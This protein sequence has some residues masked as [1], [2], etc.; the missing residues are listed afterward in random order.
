LKSVALSIVRGT[1]SSSFL[2]AIVTALDGQRLG[3]TSVLEVVGAHAV[4]AGLY[5]QVTIGDATELVLH[6][7]PG[8]TADD[9]LQA[10]QELMVSAASW[11]HVV[12]VPR[13]VA[14]PRILRPAFPRR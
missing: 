2:D 3:E 12:R 10:L 6:L 11:P 1:S 7:E 4:P 14:T 13:A 8:A 9:A 5:L